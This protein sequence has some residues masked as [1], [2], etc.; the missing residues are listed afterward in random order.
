MGLDL[1]EVTLQVTGKDRTRRDGSILTSGFSSSECFI[2]SLI[3]NTISGPSRIPHISG[4]FI[5]LGE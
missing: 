1:P 3:K 5:S 2:H 4:K